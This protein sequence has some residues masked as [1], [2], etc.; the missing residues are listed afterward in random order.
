MLIL[1]FYSMHAFVS[2]FKFFEVG[3]KFNSVK[4]PYS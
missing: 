3:P 4:K 1:A 2:Q